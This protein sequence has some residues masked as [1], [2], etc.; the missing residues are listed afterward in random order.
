[1]NPYHG[2]DKKAIFTK[3]V[4]EVINQ[5]YRMSEVTADS[6]QTGSVLLSFRMYNQGVGLNFPTYRTVSYQLRQYYYYCYYYYYFIFLS[7]R[8]SDTSIGLG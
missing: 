5:N 8:C 2:T 3:E 7:V 1:M 6:L 4:E